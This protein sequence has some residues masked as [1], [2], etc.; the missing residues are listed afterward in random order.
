M[1]SEVFGAVGAGGGDGISSVF[2][3]LAAGGGGGGGGFAFG[4]AARIS[5]KFCPNRTDFVKIL[6]S[7]LPRGE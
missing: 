6:L 5:A 1:L 7:L 4:A 3:N 2:E